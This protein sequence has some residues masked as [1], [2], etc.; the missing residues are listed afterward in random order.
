MRDPD[1]RISG[2]ACLWH[3]K[4]VKSAINIRFLDECVVLE[5]RECR[6]DGRTERRLTHSIMCW[7]LWQMRPLEH[8]LCERW[9]FNRLGLIPVAH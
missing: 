5:A 8:E 6:T 9:L 2:R 4:A 3:G 1:K 7:R